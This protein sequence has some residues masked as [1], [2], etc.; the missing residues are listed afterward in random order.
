MVPRA[1]S[2]ALGGSVRGDGIL[3]IPNAQRHAVLMGRRRLDAVPAGAKR[4][5][6]R[7]TRP[8][9]ALPR[10]SRGCHRSRRRHMAL[11]LCRRLGLVALFADLDVER[12][13]LLVDENGAVQS[14]TAPTA[15]WRRGEG[16]EV[17]HNVPTVARAG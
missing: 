9:S 7:A 1:Q 12:V 3:L 17:E 14:N 8:E 13:V 16:I 10:R 6:R 5:S 4:N 11:R 2:A 15:G